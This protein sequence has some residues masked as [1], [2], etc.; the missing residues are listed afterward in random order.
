[1]QSNGGLIIEEKAA[2]I[3]NFLVGRLV[4]SAKKNLWDRLFLS[5]TWD[6]R[7]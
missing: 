2:D 3:G 1:M 5:T 6:R 7:A 4:P